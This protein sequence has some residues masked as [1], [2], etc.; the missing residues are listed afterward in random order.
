MQAGVIANMAGSQGVE[1]AAILHS[2]GFLT[3]VSGAPAASLEASGSVAPSLVEAA[4]GLLENWQEGELART[5][6]LTENGAFAIET[7]NSDSS[8]VCQLAKG[9]N[10]GQIRMTMSD[11]CELLRNL[12]DSS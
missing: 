3:D 12:I 5:T 4:A 6:L 1:W 2:E 10:L 7:V 9:A 8:L 11:T